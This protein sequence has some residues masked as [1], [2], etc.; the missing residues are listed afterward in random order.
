MRRQWE[1]IDAA[2]VK[3]VE[4]GEGVGV[5]VFGALDGFGFAGDWSIPLKE[6]G[7]RF[8]LHSG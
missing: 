3:G 7:V 8:R 1:G 5:A 6:A 2:F 4:L